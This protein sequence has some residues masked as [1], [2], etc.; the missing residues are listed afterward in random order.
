MLLF[1]RA[2]VEGLLRMSRTRRVLLREGDRRAR[3][4]TI[5]PGSCARSRRSSTPFHSPRSR[6]RQAFRSQPARASGPERASRIRAIGRR[7]SDSSRGAMRSKHRTRSTRMHRA[8]TLHQ[9]MRRKPYT[10]RLCGNTR[11]A[12]REA[13]G[14]RF[15]R[16]PLCPLGGGSVTAL[17]LLAA[18]AGAQF[19][20]ADF[21][22]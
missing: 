11:R 21:V 16:P 9:A 8:S 18:A 19:V 7:S 10:T 2:L 14:A 12:W 20:A 13:R 22:G 15:G 5:R 3:S 4:S 1:R 6:R 17:V